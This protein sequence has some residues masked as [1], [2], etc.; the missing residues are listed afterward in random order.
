MTTI[1]QTYVNQAND[2]WQAWQTNLPK[3]LSA[4]AIDFVEQANELLAEYIDGVGIELRGEVADGALSAGSELHFTAHGVFKHFPKVIELVNHPIAKQYNAQAFRKPETDFSG[5]FAIGMNGL[6]LSVQDLQFAIKVGRYLIDLEMIVNKSVDDDN[7]VQVIQHMAFIL[8]DHI[9]GEFDGVVKIGS[10]DFVAKFSD[11][12]VVVSAQDLSVMVNKLWRDELGRDDVYPSEYE[13]QVAKTTPTDEQDG[14]LFIINSSA[15]RLIGGELA[16]C[17]RII[18]EYDSQETLEISR[19]LED[20]LGLLFCQ[21]NQAIN[22]LMV[23][24]MTQGQRIIHC[25]CAN[26]DDIVPKIK[27]IT[28]KYPLTTAIDVEYDVRWGWYCL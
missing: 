17:V 3:L 4:T 25:Y 5:D 28:A 1:K 10:V 16:W 20:E 9:L 27:T 14:L 18:S 23:N 2:F 7:N 15:N 11:D 6:E 13:L 26:P 12:F 22:A 21:D 8:L 24:N 19:E